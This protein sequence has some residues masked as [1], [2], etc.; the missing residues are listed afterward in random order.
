[1]KKSAF[2]AEKGCLGGLQNQPRRGKT[3]GCLDENIPLFLL[4]QPVVL[5]K[6]RRMSKTNEP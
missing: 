2:F 5:K 4:K 6:H 1:M 3:T